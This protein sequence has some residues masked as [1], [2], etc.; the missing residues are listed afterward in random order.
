[1]WPAPI[2][3]IHNTEE[4]LIGSEFDGFIFR[5]EECFKEAL[6]DLYK[7]E[8]KM[9]VQRP[10]FNFSEDVAIDLDN[11]HEE[12]ARHAHKRKKYADEVAHLERV[13]KQHKKKMDL[14][15]S[16]VKKE[17]ARVVI[18]TKTANPKATVQ[19]IDAE[20]I[21]SGDKSLLKER[22]IFSDLQ[23]K[24]IDLEYDLNIAKNALKGMDD[25]KTAMENE[26]SLW[27]GQ[28]FATPREHRDVAAGKI[29]DKEVE[30]QAAQKQR[31]G[32]NT[33]KRRGR[34]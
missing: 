12:W 6:K 17:E 15:L 26:V 13:I 31:E 2:C 19:Q 21:T 10:E 5:C 16:K 25:K 4:R 14:Q 1:M 20:L 22:D 29:M 28:Y 3:K 9:T 8:Q 33:R 30:G 34:E 7:K 11:L 27:K 24:L 32:L 18:F 23:D